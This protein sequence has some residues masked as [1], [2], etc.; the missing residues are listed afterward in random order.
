MCCFVFAPTPLPVSLPPTFLLIPPSL[1]L[2]PSPFPFRTFWLSQPTKIKDFYPSLKMRE[3]VLTFRA[4]FGL[5]WVVVSPSSS[6]YNCAFYCTNPTI[7]L[8]FTRSLLLLLFRG[9]IL[10]ISL[11]HVESKIEEHQEHN[12]PFL[13]K[14]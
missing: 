3:S 10:L 9:S 14:D 13:W 6:P 5:S 4:I 11:R 12:Y 1:S 2:I 7:L 8:C